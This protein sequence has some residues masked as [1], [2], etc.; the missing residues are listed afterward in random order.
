MGDYYFPPPADPWAWLA[1]RSRPLSLRRRVE[2]RAREIGLIA[3][4][5]A[6]RAMTEALYRGKLMPDMIENWEPPRTC[7]CGGEIRQET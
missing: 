1:R 6:L 7:R 2:R 4:E 3:R 5:A